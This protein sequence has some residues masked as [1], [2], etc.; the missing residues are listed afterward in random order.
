M[1]TMTASPVEAV[2]TEATADATVAT[3]D[4]VVHTAASVLAKAVSSP[5]CGLTG[6]ERVLRA[7][8]SNIL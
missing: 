5:G 1:E 7:A 6:K 8:A 3:A 4:S 2:A